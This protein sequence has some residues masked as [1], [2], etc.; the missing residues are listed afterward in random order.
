V[1]RLPELVCWLVLMHLPHLVAVC[2]VLAGSW[3]CRSPACF[4]KR[5]QRED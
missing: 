3:P 4:G 5:K 1:V 2:M